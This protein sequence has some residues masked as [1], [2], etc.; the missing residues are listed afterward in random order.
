MRASFYALLAL[1][2]LAACGS[3]EPAVSSSSGTAISPNP[4]GGADAN[5]ADPLLRA[6][7][8]QTPDRA[9]GGGARAQP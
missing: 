7:G 4:T 9:S 2:F 3:N 5:V 8:P 1:S 6:P